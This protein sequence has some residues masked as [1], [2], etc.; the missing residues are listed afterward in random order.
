MHIRCPTCGAIRGVLE[1]L[2]VNPSTAKWAGEEVGQ[3]IEKKVKRKLNKWTRFLKKFTFRKKKKREK[4]KDYLATRTRSAARAWKR[5][6]RK[7]RRS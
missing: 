6:K 2:G 7:K 5:E 3:R 4:P 1:E